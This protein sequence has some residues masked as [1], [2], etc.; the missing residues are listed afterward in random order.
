MNRS[1]N[2]TAFTLVELLV[3]IAIIGILIGML[4]PAVQQV[5]EA[6]RR[7]TCMNNIRQAALACLNY[8]S[9][10][11]QFPPGLN[12]WVNRNARGLPVTPRP[13]NPT[14]GWRYGWGMYI[15]PYMEQ[16]NIYDEFRDGTN[17]WNLPWKLVKGSDGK[18]LGTKVIPAFICPSDA[19]GDGDYNS[20]R[21]HKTIVAEG[22][23]NY[24]KSCYVA[25]IGSC[26]RNQAGRV[27]DKIHWGIFARNSRTQFG[28]ISDGSSNVILL[29]ERSSRT[30]FESGEGSPD[31]VSY[32][33]LW[34]GAI[35]KGDTHHTPNN[36]EI[37]EHNATMGEGS[38]N[39]SAVNARR[40]GV[41]GTRQP[42]GI[43]SSFHPGGAAVAAAD[44]SAHF[45]QENINYALLND[46]KAMADGVVV[47][48]F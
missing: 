17:R 1:F 11:Q 36:R 8:E 28:H 2:R 30:R 39:D 7:T 32:G 46:L 44:G 42:R 35:S 25:C 31:R 38:R 41:N 34:Q 4:L 33:A 23:G 3:V 29:G 10:F 26:D 15:L 21:T 13:S 20:I 27:S 12:S 19:K 45:L 37:S 14:R 18:Y 16:N 40:Y 24:S 22:A 47:A 6:A 48:G 43:A 9:S 5:R